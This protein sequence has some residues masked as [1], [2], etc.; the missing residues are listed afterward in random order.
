M[1]INFWNKYKRYW[2]LFLL[3]I[4]LGVVA[5]FL[6]IRYYSVNQYEVQS[7]ILLNNKDAGQ[8]IGKIDN[9]NNLGLVKNKNSLDDE[10]GIITSMDIM[11]EVIVKNS[12]N[13]SYYLEG[14][15]KDVEIYD[16]EVPF[17]VTVDETST[18]FKPNVPIFIQVNDAKTYQLKAIYNDQELSSKHNFG[19]LVKLPFGTYTIMG[20]PD[21]A[22]VEGNN[23][24][25][26]VFRNKSDVAADFLKRFSVVPE[27]KSGGLLNLRFLTNHRKKGEDILAR[28]IQTYIDRTINYENELAENT[29]QMIDSRLKT[30]SGEINEVEETVVEFKTQNNY[31]DVS[32]NTDIYLQ[33]SNDYK[34][35]MADYETQINVL[36]IIERTLRNETPTA[37]SGA[38][39]VEDPSL[40][41]L[42]NRYNEKLLEV[43]RM[44]QSASVSNPNLQK[45]NTDL[46]NLRSSI[47]QSI[48]GLKNG[49]SMAYNNLLSN[50]SRFD[51]KI[52]MVPAMEKKLLDISRDK[53]TKE[54]LYLFLLQKR[55]EEVLS[56]A[57]PVSS[58]RIVSVPRSGRFPISP[59]K[60]LIYFTG[61]LFGM[62]IPFS[63]IYIKEAF[64]TKVRTAEDITNVLSVP[65]IG[66]VY[67]SK[68]KNL[69]IS[70]SEPGAPIAETFRLL[71]FNLDYLKK[72]ER[73]Q[74]ILVTSSM[75][76]EG[77]TFV[78]S[79]LAL[80][81]AMNGEKVVV[82]SF[83]L[84]EPQL[85]KNF[86][87]PDSPGITDFILKRTVTADQI[88][89]KHPVY[90]DLCLV[91]P[92]KTN[93][94]I[95]RL[96]FSK[97]IEVLIA[98]LKKRF[99]K[100]IIDTAPIGL[101]S[102]AFAL[103]PYI[104]TTIYVIRKDVTKKE[105]FRTIENIYKNAKLKNVMVL[106]NGT[107]P[108]SSYGYGVRK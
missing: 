46:G 65:L 92:G 99:D 26:F 79:N 68:D 91:G 77:K 64:N 38:L 2:L 83:D 39:S 42:I 21:G 55:E 17:K 45:V 35:R 87:M 24:I 7:K 27:N 30:L 107:K 40:N 22:K 71:Q 101:I 75:K 81:M 96:L 6:Y 54:G 86:D 23:S 43:Q 20:K 95:G 9:F 100:V 94:E 89:Q 41:N 5:A 15:I 72:T 16:E 70:E 31:T 102:D 34:K 36:E 97:R 19:E 57:A 73:N 106:F 108:L 61:L 12:F 58:T 60:K 48:N 53:S 67:E 98:T 93:F 10:M 25:Y 3:C 47:Q 11:E 74:T 104:D 69:V 50:A 63:G 8:G 59:N 88:I 103:N 32:N 66:E 4:V 49:L 28:I 90:P 76:G 51:A 84:R 80:S 44:S 62:F 1:A 52:A 56:L 78:A 85:M 18:S 37:I 33:Q 13:I 14:D 105:H 29:I 82:V